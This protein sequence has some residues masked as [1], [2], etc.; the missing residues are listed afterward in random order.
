MFAEVADLYRQSKKPHDIFWNNY[1]SRPV[2]AFVLFFLRGT[3]LTPNQVT[4]GSLAVALGGAALMILWRTWPGLIV[5][6]LVLQASYVLDC[7][8]GQLARLKAMSTPVGAHLDFLMDELKAFAVLAAVAARL[9]LQRGDARYLLAG[10]C[11]LV[12]VASAISLTTF[13]RRP[14]YAPP[15]PTSGM[16][17]PPPWPRHPVKLAARL[18]LGAA[19][20]V[21]HYPSYMLWL[22]L[23]D[24]IDL[25]F[26]AYIAVHIVYVGRS[27]LAILWKLGR[28]RAPA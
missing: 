7:V 23:A 13:I 6:A 26:F 22:A 10:L 3:P 4:F 16:A 5:S 25:Y 11:G 24:R 9:W 2:A 28:G 15:P 27:M 14:E 18:V 21:A 1:V 12:I 20:Y 19:K 17:P 8:D